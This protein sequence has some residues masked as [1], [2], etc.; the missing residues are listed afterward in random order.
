MSFSF[1]GHQRCAQDGL[2]LAA[3]IPQ[4]LSIPGSGFWSILRN[5][6]L[7]SSPESWLGAA[8]CARHKAAALSLMAPEMTPSS[9]CA[10]QK[11]DTLVS[12]LNTNLDYCFIMGQV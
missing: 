9:A 3:P 8:L 4:G 5:L 6:P 2:T 12:K 1:W 11:S 10:A 7:H